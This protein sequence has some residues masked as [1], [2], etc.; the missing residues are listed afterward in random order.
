[1]TERKTV[2]S[3]ILWRLAERG[4]TQAVSFLVS[5][6]LARLLTP[7]D[8]GVVSLVTVFTAILTLFVDGGFSSALIQNQKTDQTDYSTVFYFNLFVSV[9]LYGCMY[10]AAPWIAVFYAQPSLTNYIRVLSLSLVIGGANGVQQA[11][12][13]KRMEYRRFFYASLS[14]TLLSAMV[15]VV[16]ALLGLGPWALVAQRLIDQ[17]ADAVILWFTVKWRPSFRFSFRRLKPLASY[18]GK[19][20][21]SSLLNSLVGNFT[22]LLI[23]KVYSPSELAYYDK[24]QRVP[25]LLVSNL[26][27][28]VQS[29]LFPAMARRQS[30]R[31]ELRQ[32][33]RQ[34]V[35]ASAYCIF[36]C[37]IGVAS[38][39]RPLVRVLFTD[40]W[41]A[42][43]PYLRLW[44]VVLL[45]YLLHTANLQVIQAVGRSDIYLR[46]EL[47]KQALSMAA[48][49]A[50]L[51][52]GAFAVLGAMAA[53]CPVH[54]YINAKPNQELL[55]YGVWAQLRDIAPI[56]GL[57]A[58]LAIWLW[59][60]SL[61]PLPDFA[62][63]S[64]QTLAGIAFYLAG[65]AVLRIEIFKTILNWT[66]QTIQNRN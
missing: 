42:L 41:I 12:V 39:A 5:L 51:P 32:M 19:M 13:A 45:F 25:M 43:V 10:M 14:G 64:V 55:G 17:A 50:A 29:V 35:M 63:L 37:M 54:F 23:G 1:M 66:R 40:R 36:P 47:L 11:L 26:Q 18:G 21:G 46:Q 6:V 3:N 33:L 4:G 49:L 27:T 44:C 7:E 22:S 24:S 16:L 9:I 15:G 58:A 28:A 56:A 52:F 48:V 62:L 20:L 57:N 61:L 34:S 59:L 30:E 31:E 8:Y 53:M 60:L 38:C 2:V 65:S